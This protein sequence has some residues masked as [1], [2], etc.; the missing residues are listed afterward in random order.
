M[1]CI[2]VCS[3]C[4]RR[5]GHLYEA[6]V[7]SEMGSVCEIVLLCHIDPAACS[8]RMFLRFLRYRLDSG[9]LLSTLKV[10]VAA[11]ASFRSPLGGQSIG[12]HALVVSFSCRCIPRALL[13]SRPGS[14]E[15]VFIA[16]SQLQTRAFSIR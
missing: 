11:I 2:L 8:C 9:S 6:F 12:R 7:C 14:L 3:T 13:Q 4:S 5:R 16:L 1:P 15:V 10:Y